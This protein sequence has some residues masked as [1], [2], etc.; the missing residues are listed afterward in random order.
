MDP[1]YPLP[2]TVRQ[3][4]VSIFSRGITPQ[5]DNS[6]LQIATISPWGTFVPLSVRHTVSRTFQ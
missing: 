5:K 3:M 4:K 2:V 1:S 6:H